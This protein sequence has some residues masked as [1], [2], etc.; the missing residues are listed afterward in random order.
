[1]VLR[2]EALIQSITLGF[3]I[4]GERGDW[5]VNVTGPG[6]IANDSETQ[7]AMPYQLLHAMLLTTFSEVARQFPSRVRYRDATVRR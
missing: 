5:R 4:A 6:H 3:S 2:G 7:D 1:M